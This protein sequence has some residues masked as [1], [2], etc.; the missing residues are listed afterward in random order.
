[1]STQ[2][3]SCDVLIVGAGMAGGY[4]AHQLRREQPD[5]DVIVFDKKESS[6]WWVGASPV[7]V[8]DDYIVRLLGLGLYM[9]SKHISKHGLRFFF[10]S[11]ERNLLGTGVAAGPNAIGGLMEAMMAAPSPVVERPATEVLA[12]TVK[13]PIHQATEKVAPWHSVFTDS[14]GPS[15]ILDLTKHDAPGDSSERGRP[16]RAPD[17]AHALGAA[18]WSRSP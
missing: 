1:M 16:G 8:F 15:A 3:Q 10:D 14:D 2:D 6:D 17:V 5:L 11:A 9:T 4:L 7:E 13:G 18:G 12:W